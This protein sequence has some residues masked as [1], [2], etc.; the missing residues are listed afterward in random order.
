MILFTK[1]TRLEKMVNPIHIQTD[2]VHSNRLHLSHITGL[3]SASIEQNQNYL[4]PMKPNLCSEETETNND[5]IPNQNESTENVG[6]AIN[7]VGNHPKLIIKL[8]RRPFIGKQ[9]L[10]ENKAVSK[11]K[12]SMQNAKKIR[13]LNDNYKYASISEVRA[14]SSLDNRLLHECAQGYANLSTIGSQSP[15]S[16]NTSA[17]GFL[18]QKLFNNKYAENN[19]STGINHKEKSIF[20]FPLSKLYHSLFKKKKRELEFSKGGNRF[21]PAQILESINKPVKIED[22]EY[23]KLNKIAQYLKRV[24]KRRAVLSTDINR[25]VRTNQFSNE[26]KFYSLVL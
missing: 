26:G 25:V 22:Y 18:T 17:P 19:Y 11:I 5:N 15:I 3:H 2:H 14:T 1:P 20:S 16:N 9:L 23:R 12:S 24:A 8:H 21:K 13:L 4:L 7:E 6:A 10:K